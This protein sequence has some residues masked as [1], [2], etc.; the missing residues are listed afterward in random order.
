MPRPPLP[1]GSYGKIDVV[2]WPCGGYLARARFRDE[3]GVT[4]KVERSGP[5]KT[6]A[7]NNLLTAFKE[8]SHR[9][10]GP[11]LT[12]DSRFSVAAA[13]W[14][15]EIV[16]GANAGLMSAN[17]A[18]LYERQLRNHAL[19]AL[20]ALCLR[21]VT[22]PRVDTALRRLREDYGAST[23]KT[24]RS[25][26]SG[27]MQLSIRYGAAT[28]NPAREVT[29]ISGG[30]R[31]QPRALT[32]QERE[33]WL[34]RLMAD[35][36]AV[37]AD[38][39]DLTRWMLATGVR[40]GEALAISWAEVGL[41]AGTVV[42][43]W[44]IVRVRGQGLQ[45]VPR[46]K[47]AHEDG[48]KTRGLALPPFAIEMLRRRAAERGTAGPLFPSATGTW[49][50]PSNTRRD[51]RNARGTEGFRWVTSHVFRKTVATVLDDAGHTARAVA[52]QL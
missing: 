42:I 37:R 25:V 29:R 22:T 40:I 11:E 4:R 45:R 18:E 24:T 1:I 28:A 12:A 48:E 35:P 7:R 13:L 50:D 27:V 9:A 15:A 33:E 34:A 10:S 2:P 17:T 21:E 6:A 51:L 36:V 43:A 52:D 49:R 20:G 16:S 47:G 31:R 8:R 5:T 26:I 39:P 41:H 44:K 19:P 30:A 46:L 3:D 23:A 14:L 32:V 38:L